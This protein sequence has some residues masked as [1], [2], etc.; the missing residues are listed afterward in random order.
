MLKR[1]HCFCRDRDGLAAVEFALILPVMLSMFLGI[2]ELDSALAC[3][4]DV[5]SMASTDSDLVAQESQVTNADMSNVFSALNEMLYPYPTSAAKIVVTSI[6]DNGSGDGKVAWSDAQNGTARSV[7]S[8]MTVPAGLLASGGSVILTEITYTYSS[9]TSKYI[10][11]PVTMTNSFYAKP[12]RV[13]QIAR[14]SS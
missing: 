2:A 14:V 5:V 11:G 4:S 7:G 10:T 13:A 12:R 8:P 9:A 1:I 6:I 3:R